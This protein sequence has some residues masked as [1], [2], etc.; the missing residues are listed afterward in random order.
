MPLLLNTLES[1]GSIQKG[2]G[3][4]DGLGLAPL[5]HVG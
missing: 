4:S 1:L 5:S 3:H 2:L